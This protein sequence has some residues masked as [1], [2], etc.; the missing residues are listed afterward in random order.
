MARLR[1]N[2]K[3]KLTK[4]D[5]QK[6][7]NKEKKKK[8]P[9]LSSIY[10]DISEYKVSRADLNF[11]QMRY[12]IINSCVCEGFIID[13]GYVK[14]DN[15]WT[16]LLLIML[17][18]IYENFP[19]KFID[20]LGEFEIT[21]S[22]FCVDKVY[23]KY[24]F[25]RQH[26]K[27]YDIYDSGYILEAIFSSENIF[28]A[29]NGMLKCLD[30]AYDKIQFSVKNPKYADIELNFDI[31]DTDELIVDINGLEK[32]YKSGTFLVSCEIMKATTKVN[33]LDVFL[34]IFCNWIF[35]NY[36]MIKLMQLPKLNG[37]GIC[38][39]ETETNL[40]CT[41]IRNSMVAVYTDNEPEDM[42]KFIKQS[43]KMLEIGNDK[44]KFKLRRLKKSEDKKEWEL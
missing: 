28:N 5:K 1:T 38:L 20:K 30:I 39:G 36:G 8:G 43:M 13:G 6:K 29:I 41:Y 10:N 18:T 24:S 35:D 27:A 19:E 44:I 42:Y 23:G 25:D 17:H 32:E 34:V 31:V 33:R 26:Y 7:V 11:T 37:T 4:T 22:T 3:S 9:K 15:S 2:Y 21:N 12:G 40:A 16:E 14:L